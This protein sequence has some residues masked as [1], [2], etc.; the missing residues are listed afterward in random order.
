[1]RFL[2]FALAVALLHDARAL[3]IHGPTSGEVVQI[4]PCSPST[5]GSVRVCQGDPESNTA[6]TIYDV[7]GQPTTTQVGDS[8]SATQTSNNVSATPKS[9]KTWGDVQG[10]DHCNGLDLDCD[11]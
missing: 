6:V 9:G 11:N 3:S 1:M 7:T 4:S 5:L 10:T 8:S 2:A